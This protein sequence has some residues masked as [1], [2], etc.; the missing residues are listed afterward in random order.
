MIGAQ[1]SGRPEVASRDRN[2]CEFWHFGIRHIGDPVDKGM[3]HSV[4]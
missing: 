3:K 2:W 4:K 1:W